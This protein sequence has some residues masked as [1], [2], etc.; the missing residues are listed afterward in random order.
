[1]QKY[2]PLWACVSGEMQ[3]GCNNILSF[4]WILIMLD[5]P[6]CYE[7]KEIQYTGCNYKGSYPTR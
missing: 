4:I 3:Q 1:L 6:L 7:D 5:I 2:Y